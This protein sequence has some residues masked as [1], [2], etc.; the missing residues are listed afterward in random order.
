RR[1]VDGVA[2]SANPW[3]RE[4]AD[5]LMGYVRRTGWDVDR[6]LLARVLFLPGKHVDGVVS[7]G[8]GATH[9]RVVVDQALLE[10]TMGELV[11]AKP[12]ETPDDQP[13]LW[14]DWTIAT[15]AP[16]AGAR[17]RRAA[18]SAVHR[19]RRPHA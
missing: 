8:G 16:A 6:N 18:G 13:A 1:L 14:P 5:Y 11:E 2:S 7:Y 17:V 3:S 4:I 10:L 12:A 15:I 9:A 19:G